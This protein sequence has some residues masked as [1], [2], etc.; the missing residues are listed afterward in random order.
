M[1]DLA[2]DP[3]LA[4]EMTLKYEP[5]LNAD[6]ERDRLKL[7]ASCCMLTANVHKDGFGAV[8]EAR[9]KRGIALIAQGYA[10]RASRAP[11]EVFD[12]AFLPAQQDRMLQ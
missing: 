4:V 2:R 8:D 12:P 1:R 9:L 7:A 6:I 3:N 5:L 10:C 11:R